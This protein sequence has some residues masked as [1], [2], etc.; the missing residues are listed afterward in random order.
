MPRAADHWYDSGPGAAS[1]PQLSPLFLSVFIRD[2][3]Q[4][5]RL[6]LV[7]SALTRPQSCNTGDIRAH[8]LHLNEHSMNVIATTT[9]TYQS[10]SFSTSDISSN[11]I[12]SIIFIFSLF[13]VSGGHYW[14]TDQLENTTHNKHKLLKIKVY[15][16][17]SGCIRTWCQS[18]VMSHP[19]MSLMCFHSN[20]RRWPQ[21]ASPYSPC[22]SN[23]LLPW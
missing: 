12:T 5:V 13:T 15:S 7:L 19:V 2:T 22:C 8:A 21:S 23:L 9:F 3:P 6:T 11:D 17:W 1:C 20:S 14:A 16:V 4:S 10:C 18:F